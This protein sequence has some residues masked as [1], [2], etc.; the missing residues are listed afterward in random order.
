MRV[1]ETSIEQDLS[2]F[3]A[4]L[5]QQRVRHRV[6]EERG[7]QVLEV[8]DPGQAQTVRHAYQAWQ[9][10]ELTLHAAARPARR[11]ELGRFIRRH[12]ALMS[13]FALAV[14]V[15]PFTQSLT[16]GELSVVSRWL[17]VVDLGVPWNRAP[18][19]A[20]ALSGG[21]IWR[22]FTPVLLHF[23]AVHLLFNL[24]VLVYLGRRVEAALGGFWLWGLVLS[25]GVASNLAQ[26][27][28]NP[29]PLFGGLSGV[30]YGLLGFVLVAQRRWPAQP[31]WRVPAAFSGSL[32]FFL[33][34]FTTGITEHLFGG[35]H[36]ANTAHWSGLLSGAG[37]ALVAG[38]GRG[39]S[40]AG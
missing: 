6:F 36:V 14:V 30:G 7:T 39:A 16:A 1:I 12:P 28:I 23:G 27:A 22:W 15:F 38:P 4:Y 20:D 26:F 21:Q 40:R 25:V 24:T 11:S 35:L 32:L 3:S 31:A 8:A 17:T 9:S 18:T 37:L 13:L 10:G 2:L 5:W 29:N 33:V 34:L 19:V